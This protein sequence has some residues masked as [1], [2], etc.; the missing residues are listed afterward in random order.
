MTDN[1]ALVLLIE[2]CAEVTQRAT[3]A[4][5]FGLEEVQAGQDLTNRERLERELI[6]LAVA[7][8]LC[9]QYAKVSA[10]TLEDDKLLDAKLH[11]LAKYHPEVLD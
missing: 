11:R 7:I 5:R 3:K 1:Q 8:G 9:I 6:D 2:E 4:I 10:D